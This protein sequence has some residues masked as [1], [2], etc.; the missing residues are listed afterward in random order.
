MN[1]TQA[2]NGVSPIPARNST[3]ASPNSRAEWTPGATAFSVIPPP[4]PPV[5]KDAT[6]TFHWSVMPPKNT[7]RP[8]SKQRTAEAS[9]LCHLPVRKV[10]HPARLN[11]SGQVS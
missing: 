3:A 5:G 7:F 9:P 10:R 8:A 4:S 1:D 2:K 11:T 6:G